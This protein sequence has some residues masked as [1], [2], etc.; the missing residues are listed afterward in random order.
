MV[1]VWHPKT[2]Q[3]YSRVMARRNLAKLSDFARTANYPAN[4][5]MFNRALYGYNAFDMIPYWKLKIML[6]A[7]GAYLLYKIG[8]KIYRKF[9][10]NKK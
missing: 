10:K 4:K 1:K 8:K 5:A 9:K 3:I 2:L 6:G 7:T